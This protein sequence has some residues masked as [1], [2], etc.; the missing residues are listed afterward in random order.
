MSSTPTPAGRMLQALR[1]SRGLTLAD[2]AVLLARHGGPATKQ[3]VFNVER[4]AKT[5]PKRLVDAY[6]AAFALSDEAALP[7]YRAAGAFF[8]PTEVAAP[9][10]GPPGAEA[11]GQAAS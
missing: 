8:A 11:A 9:H 7:L 3:D 6:R 2:A 10:D 1:E 5:H 4:R